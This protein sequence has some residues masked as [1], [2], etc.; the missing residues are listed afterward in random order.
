[1]SLV[2]LVL[3]AAAARSRSLSAAAS[4]SPP[5]RSRLAAS[6]AVGV[7]RSASVS[8][9]PRMATFR[10]GESRHLAPILA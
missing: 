7:V 4:P 2:T 6:S 5:T 1:M 3:L 10:R 9:T 8:T